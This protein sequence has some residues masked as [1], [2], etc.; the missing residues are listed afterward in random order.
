MDGSTN[1]TYTH[2]PFQLRSKRV[3]L[4]P[5]AGDGTWNEFVIE[6]GLAPASQILRSAV[7]SPSPE[8]MG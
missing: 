3:R 8:I 2:C 6:D 4:H 5:P 7:L 1:E